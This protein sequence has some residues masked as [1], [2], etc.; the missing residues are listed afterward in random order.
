[1]RSFGEVPP[2]VSKVVLGAG[3]LAAGL[4]FYQVAIA[5]FL[6]LEGVSITNVGVVLTTFGLAAVVCSVPFSILSDR[7]GRKLLMLIGGLL[8]MPATIVPGLTSDFFIL[9]LSAL[10]GGAAEA[11]YISTWNAYL[12]DATSV[13]TRPATFSLSFVIFTMGAGFGSFLPAI[14]PLLPFDFFEAHR[15]AF[16]TLGLLGLLTPFAVS[17]WAADIKPVQ[18]RRSILPRKSLRILAKFSTA[19]LTIALGAGLIIPLIPTWFY[20]RFNVTDA[21]SGPVVAVSNIL[22]GLAAIGSPSI[23]KKTGLVLGI[24]A[25]Q[26][27]STLFLFAT[28]FSPTAPI[29]AVVYVVRSMLMN[30]SSPLADSL[31]MNLV[32]Q[33]E[34]ATASALNAVVWRIPNAASTIVGA[35]FLS[36]GDLSL[37]FYLCTFLYVSSITLFYALFRKVEANASA[38]SVEDNSLETIPLT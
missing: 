1:M 26:L 5:V 8:S 14:F 22:M 32:A 16:V 15:I 7:Y 2:A 10:V 19:N 6:P 31:L 29:A 28:P 34:R 12:A 18:S 17:R 3:P 27:A 9:E 25:T 30:M 36:R 24:V 38:Q 11:M 23:A 33:D 20:L 4:G 21:F 35:S 37:P 13:S